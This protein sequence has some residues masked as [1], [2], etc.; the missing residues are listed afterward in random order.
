MTRQD[1]IG[2]EELLETAALSR[3]VQKSDCNVTVAQS[4][5][6]QEIAEGGE[7]SAEEVLSEKPAASPAVAPEELK[8][9]EPLVLSPLDRCIMCS[10]CNGYRSDIPSVESPACNE[11]GELVVYR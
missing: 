10:I 6:E 1:C 9:E 8:L 4:N 11:R 3:K 5:I 2:L 7:K